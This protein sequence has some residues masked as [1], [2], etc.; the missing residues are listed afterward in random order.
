MKQEG[1]EECKGPPSTMFPKQREA[2]TIEACSRIF[3]IEG[4]EQKEAK[5]GHTIIGSMIKYQRNGIWISDKQEL[6]YCVWACG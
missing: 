4:L 1:L 3:F 5:E 6:T 2:C